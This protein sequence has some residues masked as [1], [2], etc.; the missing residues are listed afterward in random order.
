MESFSSLEDDSHISSSTVGCLVGAFFEAIS[1]SSS[2]RFLFRC[3]T[4][5]TTTS[6]YFF[7][8]TTVIGVSSFWT[9][10]TCLVV[11]DSRE[12]DLFH[13]QMMT[14]ISHHHQLGAWLGVNECNFSILDLD[15]SSQDSFATEYEQSFCGFGS[16]NS[17]SKSESEVSSS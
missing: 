17:S 1:S 11:E 8:Q 9:T 7:D 13:P 4:F 15:V 6:F 10:T 14:R 16:S 12:W 3:S 2:L 5:E